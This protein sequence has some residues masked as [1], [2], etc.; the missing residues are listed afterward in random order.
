M[1]IPRIDPNVKYKGTSYLRE[2]NAET[3]RTLE[4]A[5]VIQGTDLQPLAVITSM[6]T[7]LALQ[8]A[9]NVTP[10]LA[11][12]IQS[13]ALGKTTTSPARRMRDLATG[14]TEQGERGRRSFKGPLLKPK[15]RKK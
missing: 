9:A 7:Y 12:T 11:G 13:A 6:E 5:I 1:T 15:D 8:A 2:L 3:L 10:F 4:G 14:H